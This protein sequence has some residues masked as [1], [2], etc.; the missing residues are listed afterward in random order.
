MLDWNNKLINNDKEAKE[1][2]HK[3]NIVGRS[4]G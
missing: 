1:L 2:L 3:F 4:H